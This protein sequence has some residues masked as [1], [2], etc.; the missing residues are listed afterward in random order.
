LAKSA[1]GNIKISP[2]IE[3]KP[4]ILTFLDEGL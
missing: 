4:G 3:A 2:K 1:V